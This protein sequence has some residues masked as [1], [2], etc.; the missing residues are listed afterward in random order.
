[1]TTVTSPAALWQVFCERGGLE[2]RLKNG[3]PGRDADIEVALRETLAV[4]RSARSLG[5]WLS[6]DAAMPQPKVRIENF[7]VALLKGQEDFARMMQDILATL[8]AANAPGARHS[9]SIA[10]KFWEA[11]DPLVQTL[12]QFRASVVRTQELLERRPLLPDSRAMWQVWRNLQKVSPGG[13]NS[14]SSLFPHVPVVPAVGDPEL[15]RKLAQIALLV[16]DVQEL[17][18]RYGADRLQVVNAAH[19]MGG[20]ANLDVR[21]RQQLYAASDYWDC[22]VIDSLQRLPAR[23]TS[24]ELS[25]QTAQNELDTALSHL[26]WGD[27]WV[28]RTVHELLDILALPAWQ[29][30]HELYSVWVGTKLLEIVRAAEPST[31][32]NPVDGV[33]S[34]AFGGSK[35]ATYERL[36]QEYEI[37]AELRS[38]LAGTSPKRKTGIQPDFR[39]VQAGL[40]DA[41]DRT[42]YVLECKHYLR[43]NKLN[44]TTAAKDYAR[45]C[46]R[47]VVHVVNHGPA[48]D[49]AL[50]ASLPLELQSAVRFIGDV[51]AGSDA[52]TAKLCNAIR[53]ALFPGLT[54]ADA[55]N[56]PTERLP[57]SPLPADCV[58]QVFLEWDGSLQDIDLS[59]RVI[60]HD[61]TATQSI[62]F[63]H[64]GAL[65]APPFA[66]LH[67]DVQQ[68]PGVERID[69]GA[70]HFDHYEL[71]ATNYSKAGAM[72]QKALKC[73]VVT[74]AGMKLLCCPQDLPVTRHEWRIADLIVRGDVIEIVP[75]AVPSD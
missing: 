46:P 15:D 54:L 41:G 38:T 48:D 12:E 68:G 51:K 22:Q 8:V 44:F 14:R 27:A 64:R 24:T 6:M 26:E 37:W 52:A 13:N 19:A 73:R 31:R 17:W 65:D 28:E 60:S 42:V 21:L 1:M 57:A 40:S 43:S 9:L 53:G 71:V 32:F 4:P 72:T 56:A 45:S 39:V 47:A 67:A 2:L 59:L 58:C 63:C 62:D 66:R 33:L 25:L 30:R 69:I 16:V 55:G 61:G 20:Q 7:L 29:R 75:I 3:Q 70:W 36:G 50:C 34:F 49:A 10:F 35:L 11:D 5:S 23:I 18:Q 74:A